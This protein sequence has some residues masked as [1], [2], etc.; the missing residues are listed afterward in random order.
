MR[1]SVVFLFA[2]IL[3]GGL[4]VWLG[5]VDNPNRL[6]NIAAPHS[7]AP[8]PDFTLV[9]LEGNSHT[10]SAY[11]GRPVII[12]FWATWCAPCATEMPAFQGVYDRYQDDGLVILAINNSES[13]DTIQAFMT[14]KNLDFPVLLDSDFSATLAYKQ[15]AFPTTFF[16]DR[17]GRIQH[18][19]IGGS[20]SEA[21]IASKVSQIIK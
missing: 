11:E 6:N 14:E 3:F 15:N 10:L 7:G 12:N 20:M 19:E 18:T 13:I 2:S 9:D 8:A 5:R 1:I 17:E 4:L 16:I 21:F